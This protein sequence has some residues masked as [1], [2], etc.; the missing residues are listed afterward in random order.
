MI[1]I[2]ARKVTAPGF[3]TDAALGLED[4]YLGLD[5]TVRRR[6]NRKG[7]CHCINCKDP[8]ERE[9]EQY[10]TEDVTFRPPSKRRIHTPPNSK[11]GP[12]E[13]P[14]MEVRIVDASEEL[15]YRLAPDATDSTRPSKV[16]KVAPGA[17][18]MS[19]HTPHVTDPPK[20]PLKNIRSLNPYA[21]VQNVVQTYAIKT[22]GNDALLYGQFAQW[23]VNE[24]GSDS[25]RWQIGIHG[26]KPVSPSPNLIA[27]S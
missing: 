21:P 5:M 23:L 25:Q 7:N 9:V 3:D 16:C 22:P 24:F 2:N 10:P 27:D 20:L 6:M 11:H 4:R 14:S 8:Q 17:R 12:P 1:H 19:P 13:A 26:A 15:A 18:P